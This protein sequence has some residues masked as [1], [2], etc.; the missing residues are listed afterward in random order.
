M[1]GNDAKE[2][3]NSKARTT[4]RAAESQ[5]VED[6]VSLLTLFLKRHRLITLHCHQRHD[7]DSAQDILE[8]LALL[9]KAGAFLSGQYSDGGQG[10]ETIL[11]EP[12]VQTTFFGHDV[13]FDEE[14]TT[15]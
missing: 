14:N 8:T 7:D 9:R 13:L 3:I 15:L 4:P 11:N 5:L 1:A 10:L 12:H 6:T 2:A